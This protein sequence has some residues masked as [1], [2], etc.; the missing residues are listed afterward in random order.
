ME[1]G[2]HGGFA[3][4]WAFDVVR[5]VGYHFAYAHHKV[6]KSFGGGPVV[7]SADDGWLDVRME[8]GC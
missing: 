7:T 2:P 3:I 6:A 8:H 5:L 4:E 1:V